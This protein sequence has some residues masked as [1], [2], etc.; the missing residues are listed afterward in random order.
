M[1]MTSTVTGDCIFRRSFLTYHSN[2]A[3][4]NF[5]ILYL[6]NSVYTCVYAC[7][8]TRV[9]VRVHMCICTC[10]YESHRSTPDII[11][12]W[13]VRMTDEVILTNQQR[14]RNLPPLHF[15]LLKSHH[16][17]CYMGNKGETLN[18]LF[19]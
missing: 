1:W 19:V 9:C 15:Q 18:I 14:S 10:T 6:I 13:D 7:V 16:P 5:L 8:G 2:I 12:H 4:F 11:T 3:V 17:A